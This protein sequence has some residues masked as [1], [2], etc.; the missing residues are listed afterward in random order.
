MNGRS[1]PTIAARWGRETVQGGQG[2]RLGRIR[3]V[4]VRR[5]GRAGKPRPPTISSGAAIMFR[6]ASRADGVAI[7]QLAQLCEQPMPRGP[8]LLAEVDGQIHAALAHANRELLA[9]PYMPMAELRSLLRLR[10]AQLDASYP[11]WVCEDR[12]Q[13]VALPIS[14]EHEQIASQAGGSRLIEDVG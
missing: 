10:A 12:T 3:H 2:N 4:L 7:D 6:L 14:R 13:L 5:A 9:D 11:A 8:F 1:R